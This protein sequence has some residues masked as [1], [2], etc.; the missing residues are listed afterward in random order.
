[1]A[2]ILLV[3][4][5]GSCVPGHH[6]KMLRD[7]RDSAGRLPL[8]VRAELPAGTMRVS[9]GR[10]TD[11]YDLSFSYC[12]NHFR[13]SSRFEAPGTGA[14]ARGTGVL[15]IEGT[16]IAPRE[17]GEREPN[18]LN[19]QLRPGI[20][21]DLRLSVGE[22]AM[23]LDLTALGI[24]RLALHGG[25]GPVTLRF[26]AG[27]SLELEQMRVVAGTG[28]LQLEGLG[29]GQVTSFEFHGGSGA[30]RLDWTGPGPAE[31]AAFLDPGTGNLGL[32]F[33]ADLGVA[34]SGEGVPAGGSV[35]GFQSRGSG[36]VSSNWEASK[37]RL[38]L[39][40][41]PGGGRVTYTWMPG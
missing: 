20:P 34:L 21:L 41:D 33:P 26:K 17:G 10:A 28:A 19:L 3:L 36:W 5:A 27:N 37:R 35:P 4:A 15:E 2:V 16:P 29:W 31:S 24:R 13:A 23:D 9:M 40:L 6:V 22:G 32:F 39:V 1:V 38:T 7:R 11:L 14:D 8:S 18:L 30:A 25:T 12:R